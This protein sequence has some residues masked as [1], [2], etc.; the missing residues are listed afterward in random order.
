M[1]LM[2]RWICQLNRSRLPEAS[3][4]VDHSRI[5]NALYPLA[6]CTSRPTSLTKKEKTLAGGLLVLV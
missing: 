6:D 5:R 3:D 4:S 1:S 2:P